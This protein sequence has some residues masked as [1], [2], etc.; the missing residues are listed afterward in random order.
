VPA[1]AQALGQEDL[2]D[3][4][5]L[6]RNP[7]PLVEIGGQPVQRPRGERQIQRLGIGERGGDHGGDLLGRIGR[8]PAGA[9][10]VRQAVKASG[11]EAV[12]PDAHGMGGK[13]KLRGD[14]RDVFA[15]ASVPDDAGPLDLPGGCRTRMGQP[16]DRRLLRIRQRT[17]SQLSHGLSPAKHRSLYHDL[18]DEPLILTALVCDFGPPS[19]GVRWFFMR[20]YGGRL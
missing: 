11:P 16:L 6:D 4:A 8:R 10:S 9:A 15:P 5:A 20:E 13:A 14:A 1:P 18:P 3:P 12:D 7:L 19:R 2:V 17:Q